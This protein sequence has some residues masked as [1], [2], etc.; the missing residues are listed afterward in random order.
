MVATAT[1]RS[2]MILIFDGRKMMGRAN[3]R[4]FLCRC[5]VSFQ[6]CNLGE[7]NGSLDRRLVA[8]PEFCT[9]SMAI[10]EECA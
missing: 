10:K 8:V 6:P 9:F 7:E 2:V 4:K 3:V 5:L 1:I